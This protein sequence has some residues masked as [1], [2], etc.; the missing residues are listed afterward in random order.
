MKRNSLLIMMVL[1]LL[2]GIAKS[3]I[4][5]SLIEYDESGIHLKGTQISGDFIEGDSLVMSFK[6]AGNDSVFLS[7]PALFMSNNKL[8]GEFE[9]RYMTI[10]SVLYLKGFTP[11]EN[12]ITHID[13]GVKIFR[14]GNV[15]FDQ[16]VLN[17]QKK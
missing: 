14:S 1:M 12:S 16:H 13:I 11:F 10:N 8:G 5:T 9:G 3:Q 4:D 17:I 6:N 15:I 2:G 7:I